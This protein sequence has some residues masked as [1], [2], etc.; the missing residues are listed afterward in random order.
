MPPVD[1]DVPQ[2]IPV[3]ID[4]PSILQDLMA[5][6]WNHH[7]IEIACGFANGYVAKLRA[8]QQPRMQYQYAARL[9]NLWSA[10]PM[11]AGALSSTHSTA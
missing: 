7:R 5:Q 3:D 11:L 6:G 9:F 8:Q 2:M 10:W 4:V 1:R